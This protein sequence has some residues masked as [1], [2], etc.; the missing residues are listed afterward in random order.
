[1]G[2]VNFH[3]MVC[4]PKTASKCIDAFDGTILFMPSTYTPDTLA[5]YDY[6]PDGVLTPFSYYLLVLISLTGLST[7]L[8]M[9]D[10]RM[11]REFPDPGAAAAAAVTPD[12][13]RNQTATTPFVSTFNDGLRV[14]SLVLDYCK[15]YT[16]AQTI[17]L[18]RQ[19]EYEFRLVGLEVIM[20]HFLCD[21][22]K[23]H[24]VEVYQ[25]KNA[26]LRNYAAPFFLAVG[27]SCRTAITRFQSFKRVSKKEA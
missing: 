17:H 24:L 9:T 25:F 4:S 27:R 20:L 19:F 14:E 3:G 22:N 11:S 18:K 13:K 7:L 21:Q 26:F 15:Q 16:K 2:F 5:L 1:M 6:S 8:G 23:L 12:E 10:F